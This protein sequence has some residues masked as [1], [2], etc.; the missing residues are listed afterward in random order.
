MAVLPA[1]STRKGKAPSFGSQHPPFRRPESVCIR[2]GGPSLTR[3]LV[4]ALIRGPTWASSS[5]IRIPVSGQHYSSRGSKTLTYHLWGASCMLPHQPLK[6]F[7]HFRSHPHPPFHRHLTPLHANSPR[8]EGAATER[9]VI[10]DRP[11]PEPPKPPK[12]HE[13]MQEAGG[14]LLTLG[15]IL[16]PPEIIDP[17]EV[18]CA[19]E[20]ADA[21]EVEPPGFDAYKRGGVLQAQHQPW[22]KEPPASN[23]LAR[24]R[25]P[26]PLGPRHWHPRRKGKP[27]A[28]SRCPREKARESATRCHRRASA[29]HRR[30]QASAN[31]N[32]PR[33]HHRGAG[34]NPR[35][36]H[37]TVSANAT[38]RRKATQMR[39]S[40]AQ[41]AVARAVARSH[42]VH[43]GGCSPLGS[44]REAAEGANPQAER[45]R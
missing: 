9:R 5:S 24:L 25:E 23:P 8:G 31:S 12:P 19:A 6:Y 13:V 38:R 11:R 37:Q 30:C 36:Y 26:W 29:T 43:L 41:L 21:E 2:R 28:K 18:A 4:C 17:F 7:H 35:R 14:A 34:A 16:T 22:P 40:R 10:E 44:R 15:N 39:R 45:A 1:S 20:N 27:G 42:P 33:H 3:V 32:A